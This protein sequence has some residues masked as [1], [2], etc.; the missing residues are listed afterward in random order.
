MFIVHRRLVLLTLVHVF[1]NT[2]SPFLYPPSWGV[3]I[4]RIFVSSEYVHYHGGH[5]GLVHHHMMVKDDNG[6][7]TMLVAGVWVCVCG[8]CIRVLRL[9]GE[10]DGQA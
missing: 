8:I 9:G 7:Q 4:S 5:G 6:H 1:Y 10:G 2:I 3:Y